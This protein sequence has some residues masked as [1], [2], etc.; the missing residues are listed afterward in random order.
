MTE[1]TTQPQI[2]LLGARRLIVAAVLLLVSCSGSDRTFY[3]LGE[4]AT[5]E[6]QVS[7]GSLFGSSGGRNARVTN[8]ASRELRGLEV[9]PQRV[10]IGGQSHFLFVAG[11]QT[12]IYEYARQSAGAVE[13][14]I[15][16]TPNYIIKHPLE[17]GGSWEGFTETSLLMNK[18]RMAT[19]TTIESTDEAV[20]VPAGTFEHCLRTK[21]VGTTTYNHGAFVGMARITLEEHSWLCPGIG[22][23]KSV[24]KERSNH[25]LT[26]SGEASLELVDFKK[27]RSG[28]RWTRPP[29]KAAAGPAF[30]EEYWQGVA[31]EC[32]RIAA[33]SPRATSYTVKFFYCEAGEDHAQG[34]VHDATLEAGRGLRLGSGNYLVR[35]M[36]DRDVKQARDSG[37][38]CPDRS[39]CL[40]V[41]MFA[42]YS[43]AWEG[44]PPADTAAVFARQGWAP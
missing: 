13:P 34:S 28:V 15:L 19:R 31:G 41:D 35:Y 33:K 21:T 3:P 37:H 32:M 25:L 10:D 23:V 43:A 12:G 2:V 27:S 8:L 7:T 16:P 18:S 11:D 26:G 14:E 20:T 36:T 24:R 38:A 9:T 4:G 6:Y 22:M 30:P 5:L 42:A 29:S 40:F 39:A 1:S 17:P 44:S